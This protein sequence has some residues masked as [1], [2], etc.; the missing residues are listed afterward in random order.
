MKTN[1]Y[2]PQPALAIDLSSSYRPAL[3]LLLI[4]FLLFLL[5][6]QLAPLQS[7]VLAE[8][9]VKTEGYRKTLQHQERARVAAVLVEDGDRVS[10]GETLIILDSADLK[11]IQ[12]SLKLQSLDAQLQLIL[13]NAI[14]KQRTQL[15][16]SPESIHRAQDLGR[17]KILQYKQQYFASILFKLQRELGQLDIQRQQAIAQA[18]NKALQSRRVSQQLTLFRQEVEALETL[19]SQAMV[20]KNQLLKMHARELELTKR[21]EELDAEQQQAQL[22]QQQIR[23][24]QLQRQQALHDNALQ[25]REQIHR[26]LPKLQKDLALVSNKLAHNVIRAPISG[27]I[28]GLRV[29]AVGSHLDVDQPLMEIISEQAP[30]VIEARIKPTDVDK[31][32]L[33]QTARV[34]LSAYD[35][36]RIPLLEAEL[37]ALSADTFI[38]QQGYAY[39]RLQLRIPKV[40]L[41]R[42]PGL[43]LYPGMPVQT[44]V[45]AGER[46]LW[47]YLLNQII[48]RSEHS[49]REA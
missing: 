42:I 12:R 24:Q 30:L 40:Q 34:R 17:Q 19:S 47:E 13:L 1:Y 32:D 8:G 4:V 29:N 38:D 31:I 21:V 23:L 16:F 6:S 9:Q 43:K 20:A 14:I 25:E 49:L 18:N 27:R 26:S 33:T 46:T 10:A 15:V 5:W 37:L 22:Q 35:S 11:A 2:K 7:A 39:Y 44:I 41:E 36:R 45:H 48:Q 28:Q 3:L